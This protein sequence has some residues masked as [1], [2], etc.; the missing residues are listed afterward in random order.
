MFNSSF[1]YQYIS[2]G[3]HSGELQVSTQELMRGYNM[4]R[5]RNLM[6]TKGRTVN[7]SFDMAG[8]SIISLNVMDIVIEIC[9]Q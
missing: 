9:P 1:P 2:H 5:Y 3:K 8:Y 6:Y 7:D 4:L